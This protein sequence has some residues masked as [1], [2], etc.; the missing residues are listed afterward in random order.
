VE[1]VKEVEEEAEE[2]DGIVAGFGLYVHIPFCPQHCPYCAFAVVTGHK[3][4]Y[5]RYVEAVC[6]ELRQWRQVTDMAPLRT[7]FFGGGTPSMLGPE[8]VQRI[9]ETAVDCFGMVSGA[10]ITLEANPSTADV[11]KFAAMRQGGVNRLSLGV[12]SLDD[13]D[14][15]VLGRLHSAAEARAGFSAAR[16]AGFDNVSMDIMFSIPG[17]PRS[18]WR[19][20]VEDLL[21]LQP[22][23][24]STYALTIEEG[25]RF[26]Q[27]YHQGRLAPVSE[28]DD[29]WAYA[30][31][32]ER[33]GSAGYEHYEVSNFA[34]AGFRSRHNWGYWHGVPYIGVGLSAHTFV[35]RQRRWNTRDLWQYLSAVEAGRSP[36]LGHEAIDEVTAR[37]ERIFLQLRTCRG[38]R[39]DAS[40][41]HAIRGL[42]KFQAMVREQLVHLDAGQLRLTPR[43]FRLADAIAVEI[44]AMTDATREA[45]GAPRDDHGCASGGS[46]KTSV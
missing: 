33:L 46:H 10:E 21:A 28:S 15:K 19:R 8:Q 11:A 26:S 27:R 16:R 22:E 37:Q 23:H 5:T 1:G 3:H 20:T 32:M 18:H 13:A 29:S 17:T 30:W 39:L 41:L 35:N 2:E 14:L 44:M 7:V 45:S 34:R 31:V 4:L 38:V 6:A 42:A 9:L 24:I 43:G 36:C 25:T 12:Q 40:E